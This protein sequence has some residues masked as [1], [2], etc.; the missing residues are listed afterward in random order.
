[1]T[2]GAVAAGALTLLGAA[3][4]RY[5]NTHLLF[6]AGSARTMPDGRLPLIAVLTVLVLAAVA[7]VIVV[8]RVN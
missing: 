5:R 4:R 8:S 3:H 6:A 2:A 7:A 1:M